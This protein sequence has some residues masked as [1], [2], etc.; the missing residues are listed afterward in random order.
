M[1]PF[2]GGQTGTGGSAIDG[3]Q[4]PAGQFGGNGQVK[5]TTIG[6]YFAALAKMQS[7]PLHIQYAPGSF[8]AVSRSQGTLAP[9]PADSIKDIR[10]L[11]ALY[12]YAY[13]LQD[14]PPLELEAEFVLNAAPSAVTNGSVNVGSFWGDYQAAGSYALALAF[15]TTWFGSFEGKMWKAMNQTQA[16]SRLAAIGINP[17]S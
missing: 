1:S 9:S 17:P 10:Q 3:N 12:K 8:V 16:A 13:E 7:D 14:S 2:G 15:L 11:E 4:E 6:E 5:L